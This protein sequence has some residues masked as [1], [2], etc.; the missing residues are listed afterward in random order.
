MYFGFR[1]ITVAYGGR[2]VLE[3]VTLALERGEMASLVGQNGCGKSSLLKT[4]SRAV[5]PQ[6]GEVVYAGRPM[7]AYPRRAFARKVAYLPQNQDAPPDLDVRTLVS[8]GRYPHLRA[9]RALTGAD[10]AIVEQTL[11]Q[12]GLTHLQAR[13]IGTLSGGERQR[14]WLAMAVCR[15]P[16]VLVLDEPTTHLDMHSQ[17]ELLSLIRRFNREQGMTVLMVLHDLQLAA[18]YSDRL[19]AIADGKIAADGKPDD[20]LTEEN[21]ARIFRI[22][23]KILRDGADG[24]RY[25]IPLSPCGEE[26]MK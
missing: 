1:E 26:E 13:A 14:V 9:G 17:L 20:V 3:G 10:E 25:V 24:S 6:A 12:T 16:E 11:A 18:R 23:T 4:V 15:Q 7:L 2:R 19:V 5:V 21:L 22:R 8:Y